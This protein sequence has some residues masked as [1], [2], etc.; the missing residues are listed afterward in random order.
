MQPEI[1][2][3]VF[4]F[5]AAS[6]P[7]SVLD[8]PC[9]N[10]WLGAFLAGSSWD[11]HGADL[12]CEPEAAN[13]VAQFRNADLQKPFPYADGQFDYLACL[14]GLEHIENYHHVLREAVRV[15]KP[16]GTLLV[17]TPNPLNIKSRR[18]Y[19]WSG[20]FYGFPHL[21]NMPPEGSHIHVTPVNLSFLIAFAERYGMT[22]HRLHNVKLR[23][24]MYWHLP[25]VLAVQAY[26][27]LKTLL[28]PQRQRQWLRLLASQQVCLCDGM[29][30]SFTKQAHASAH[31]L[32]R[33]HEAA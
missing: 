26:T 25:R 11:Y 8:F 19:Y 24:G 6:Q 23:S 18:R 28:K 5:F 33:L 2:E 20:T 4:E 22:F 10:G 30:V 32:P 27:W 7:G 9:G 17:S 29:V 16:G 21:I 12:Y 15:L 13:H 3:A 31:K 1:K 14:E